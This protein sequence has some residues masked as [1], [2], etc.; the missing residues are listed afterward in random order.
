MSRHRTTAIK[1][2]MNLRP[3]ETGC[4]L[5]RPE[6]ELRQAGRG[7]GSSEPRNVQNAVSSRCP[8][9]SAVTPSSTR[10]EIVPRAI[11]PCGHGFRANRTMVLAAKVKTEESADDVDTG[12]ERG[13]FGEFKSAQ[14]EREND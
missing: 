13:L 5:L 4:A 11:G 1:T 12:G 8:N 14:V 6:G 2:M 10:A 9:M 7:S 3:D